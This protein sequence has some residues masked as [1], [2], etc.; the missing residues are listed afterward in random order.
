MDTLPI[1]APDIIVRLRSGDEAAFATVYASY[2][3]QLCYFV[4]SIVKCRHTA[5]EI[6]QDVLTKV[7][8]HRAQIDP[9]KP[10]AHW[11]RTIARNATFDHLKKIA[12]DRS[13]QQEVW[14]AVQYHKGQP[15]DSAVHFKE[16]HRLYQQAIS[17]LPPQQQKVFTLS[18]NQ[19]LTHDE[20]ALE[21]GISANTVRNHMA[22]ALVAVRRYFKTHAGCWLLLLLALIGH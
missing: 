18:R 21:L 11:V 3:H 14:H 6:V 7:W 5:E 20:I 15:A 9:D 22:A 1:V 10:F 12:R 8:L 19:A 13:L 16:Y 17:L 4:G 2:Y